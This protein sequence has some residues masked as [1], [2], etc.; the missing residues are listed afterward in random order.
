MKA[1]ESAREAAL[2]HLQQLPKDQAAHHERCDM[3]VGCEEYGVCY[4]NSQGKPEYCSLHERHPSITNRL[5]RMAVTQSAKDAAVEL[6]HEIGMSA[7]EFTSSGADILVQAIT[8]A[9]ERGRA[10][11][12][13]AIIAMLDNM[14]TE[15]SELGQT[16]AVFWIVQI[17]RDIAALIPGEPA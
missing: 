7:E 9:E 4:A 16:D 5:E 11:H 14:K 17:K 6:A 12:N 15:A 1:S 3:G 10:A 2:G 8:Q 13:A